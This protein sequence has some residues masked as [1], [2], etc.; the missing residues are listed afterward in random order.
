MNKLEQ[1]KMI[2]DRLSN[3]ENVSEQEIKN[4][5]NNMNEQDLLDLFN[6]AIKKEV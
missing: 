4:L 5:V 6:Y 2:S 3:G 1:G